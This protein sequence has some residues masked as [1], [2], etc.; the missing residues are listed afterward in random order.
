MPISIGEFYPRRQHHPTELQDV[1]LRLL[2]GF[3]SSIVTGVLVYVTF[4]VFDGP[5]RAISSSLSD[6]IQSAVF[7]RRPALKSKKLNVNSTFKMPQLNEYERLIAEN[8]VD[9]R[10]LSTGFSAI[11]GL[12]HLK[13]EVRLH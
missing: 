2:N 8:L 7:W 4:R 1:T 12:E 13:E 5:L 3:I 11:G 6:I 10:S 9:P